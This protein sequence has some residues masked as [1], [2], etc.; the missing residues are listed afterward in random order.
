MKIGIFFGGP[1]SESCIS[2]NS[3]RTIYELIGYYYNMDLYFI[4]RNLDCFSVT[5]NE[6]FT[7]K[8]DEF[9]LSLTNPVNLNDI[10]IDYA[11]II[12]FGKF[13]EDGQIQK[14]F[15]DL[16]I[17][18]LFSS[19]KSAELMYIKYNF[20]KH[21]KSSSDADF[22]NY[23][24]YLFDKKKSNL[25]KFISKHKKIIVKPNFGGSSI[26]VEMFTD[27]EKA[28]SFLSLQHDNPYLVQEYIEG[29]EFT[30]AVIDGIAQNPMIICDE[31]D[32]CDYNSKYSSNSSIKIITMDDKNPYYNDIIQ[33][34]E[35]IY[36]I[37]NARDGLRIDGII[38]NNGKIVFIDI[39]VIPGMGFGSFFFLSAKKNNYEVFLKM[40]NNSLKNNGLT[41][42][43]N[44]FDDIN[45]SNKI[46][47]PVLFG[48]N[49]PDRQISCNSAGSVI[50]NLRQSTK[51]NPVPYLL[52]N[53]KIYQIDY[54]TLGHH[55]VESMIM[56][57]ENSNLKSQ[58]W[59]E[60]LK[61]KDFVFLCMC[62]LDGNK[63]N[64]LDLYNVKYN[65]ENSNLY[66]ICL[67]KY[68]F[69]SF[70][71]DLN[72]D[73]LKTNYQF[74]Y[75][76]RNSFVDIK[77]PCIIKPLYESSNLKIL[78]SIEDFDNYLNSLIGINEFILE[79]LI[80]TES[81][82]FNK[83]KFQNLNNGWFELNIS[84]YYN[85]NKINILPPTLIANNESIISSNINLTPIPSNIINDNQIKIIKTV[86]K[87][88]I[89]RLN[90]KTYG[91]MNILFNNLSNQIN[92]IENSLLPYLTFGATIF[93][94]CLT[95]NVRPVEFLEI[96]IE[97]K[98]DKQ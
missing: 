9:L 35:K 69:K 59:N 5:E 33:Q 51:Y 16:K 4:D 75:F 81:I 49:G 50:L 42:L 37:F 57:I 66:Q 25:I 40:I 68:L 79:D 8:T 23:D 45:K 39:N 24:C 84:Y 47:I 34:S 6:L 43:P 41:Q 97:Q 26:G 20:I 62:N 71:R 83:N 77:F 86:V 76:H 72:I 92:I 65:G 56:E 21:L 55:N 27:P 78:K 18:F 61:Y 58:T 89:D 15:E 7:N 38:K 12:M 64:L 46:Q 60:F 31:S 54:K 91:S 30:I 44:V 82:I 52:H 2:I 32:V 93:S 1:P 94:Q 96:I 87:I 90:I 95:N 22:V 53:E 36:K 3:A 11:I 70:V 17:P 63:Q 74:K 14:I 85:N 10:K 88:I 73:N 19:S 28:W 67:N 29:M 98:L 48:G 80:T 13:G